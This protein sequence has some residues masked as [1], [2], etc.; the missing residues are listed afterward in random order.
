MVKKELLDD[1][2]VEISNLNRVVGEME[3]WIK[4]I[5]LY[6]KENINQKGFK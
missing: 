2:K 4:E 1:L 3:E 5:N 6:L